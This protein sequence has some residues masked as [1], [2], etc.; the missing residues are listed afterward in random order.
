MIQSV[1]VKI[2][3]YEKCGNAAGYGNQSRSR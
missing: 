2:E 3:R 1:L